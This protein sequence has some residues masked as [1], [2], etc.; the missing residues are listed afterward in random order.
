ML[1]RI[2]SH[3][4]YIFFLKMVIKT[5]VKGVSVTG[6]SDNGLQ[7]GVL[8]FGDKV[9]QEIPLGAAHNLQEFISEAQNIKFKNDNYNDVEGAIEAATEML[10]A[11]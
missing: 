7:Y 6:V 8:Q 4:M 10:K 3:R 11:R 5:V 1:Q 2:R 9:Y